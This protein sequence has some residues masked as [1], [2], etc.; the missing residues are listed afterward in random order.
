[1]TIT[2]YKLSEPDDYTCRSLWGEPAQHH[3]KKVLAEGHEIE[4][5]W[6]K[7]PPK[8]KDFESKLVEV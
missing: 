5:G 3:A 2:I 6:G 4:P 8:V 1:M 7:Q